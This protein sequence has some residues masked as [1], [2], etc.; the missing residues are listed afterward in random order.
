VNGRLRA[1]LDVLR[2]GLLDAAAELEAR[3]DWPADELALEDDDAV[4]ARLRAL[5]VEAAALASTWARARALV[6]GCRV[7][8]VGA[9]NAGKS[10]LFNQLV[11]RE[12]RA[13]GGGRPERAGGHAAGHGG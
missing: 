3:L 1:P 11:G 4:R 13:G 6:E 7:A 10:S 12:R 8:L 5:A 9:V 2:A